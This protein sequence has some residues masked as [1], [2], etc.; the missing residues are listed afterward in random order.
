MSTLS[1]APQLQSDSKISSAEVQIVCT[2]RLSAYCH[3]ALPAFHSLC[4]FE[5]AQ[6]G[7]AELKSS[8][9]NLESAPWNAIRSIS[10][11][12]EEVGTWN[13]IEQWQ[14]WGADRCWGMDKPD[15]TNMPS[16]LHHVHLAYWDPDG[17]YFT[18]TEQE[19]LE[20]LQSVF[21]RQDLEAHIG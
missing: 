17:K 7:L 15:F 1:T 8:D 21:G 12:S 6:F 13:I 9:L 5:I 16:V 3:E 18:C 19:A 10:L 14:E 4:R 20:I 2:M 11:I